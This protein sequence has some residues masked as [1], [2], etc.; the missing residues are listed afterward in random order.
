MTFVPT[1]PL[2]KEVYGPVHD[3]GCISKGFASVDNRDEC[4]FLL[5]GLNEESRRIIAMRYGEALSLRE[6][7]DRL[8]C[9]SGRVCMRHKSILE[10]LR[11]RA[12]RIG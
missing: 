11:E 4:D 5:A 10:F 9:S 3:R 2:V 12:A 8:G 7:A 1:L 6:I